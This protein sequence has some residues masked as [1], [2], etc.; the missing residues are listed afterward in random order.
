MSDSTT[1]DPFSPA[2][3]P[4][5]K[6]ITLDEP[7]QWLAA[8]WYDLRQAPKFSLSYGL[9]FVIISYLLT[10]G[11]INGAMFFLI[12]PLAAAFFLIAPLLGIGLYGVSRAIEQ[13]QKVE[14]CQ[15]QQ[16]WE[17]NPAHI[18]AMGIVLML[19]MLAWMLAANLI[20]VLFFDKPVPTWEDF[21]PVVFLS[22]DSPLFLM[23]GVT[24][25]GIIALFTFAISAVTVPLLMDRQIDV[26]TAMQSS[27][28]AVRL[29][30]RP[31]MLWASLIAMFVGVGI[32]TFYLGLIVT[33]PL[34]GHA[35][36]HAYR[37]L[38][39]PE[40]EAGTDESAS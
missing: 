32:F 18:S 33:M 25:G 27:F 40:A 36:W 5:I 31:M 4:R 14:F 6:E 39:A 35:T 23:V 22:G 1:L 16:A 10:L 24:V 7:W 13:G 17:S 26:M 21:I 9:A 8:G 2:P 38:V 3:R 29:N 15:A 12:P 28:A 30:W 34:V 20:F 19:I 11:L 37:D